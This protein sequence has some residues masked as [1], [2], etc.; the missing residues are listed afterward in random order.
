VGCGNFHR[1][2]TIP[3]RILNTAKKVEYPLRNVDFRMKNA[4]LAIPICALLLGATDLPGQTGIRPPQ[5]WS[6]GLMGGVAAFTDMQ[7]SSLTVFR[8]TS[9]GLE[10][11][12]LGR[13]IGAETS[14]ALGGYLSFWPTRNWGLR[15]YGTYAPT[16]LEAIMR[17]DHGSFNPEAPD[18][19]RLAG[20]DIM[21][22]DL[23]AM[24]RLPTIKNRVLLYG[25][26][27]AGLARYEVRS[28]SEN[29]PVPEE[30]QGDLG[31]GPRTHPAGMFGLGAMLPFRNRAYRLHFELSNHIGETP[32]GR[33]DDQ[34]SA[35][36][37]VELTS[38]VRFMVGAS[39]SPKH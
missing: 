37:P 24:F 34:I 18:T 19:G 27:G 32:L 36:D 5:G 15:L 10:T 4:A 14:T 2:S 26:L 23:Q 29:E 6:L 33:T 3:K 1:L 25:I 21:T 30:A 9:T 13:R 16:R 11:R 17:G 31:A 39:W 7:R 8:T 38:S 20:L 22:A 35:E 28:S 12:D